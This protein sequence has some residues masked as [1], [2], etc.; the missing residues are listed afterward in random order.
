MKKRLLSYL[1][2]IFASLS[3]CNISYAATVSI[4][5]HLL[6]GKDAG[7]I[8]GNIV[9]TDSK[10]GLLL[11]PHL[12]NLPPGTHGFHIHELASCDMAGAAAGDH[13]DP[14]HTGKHLG[15]ANINGHLGDL[16]ALIVK[17]DGTADTPVIAPRLTVANIMEHSVIIHA[18]GDN[19]A[20]TP[21]KLGGGGARI[22]CGIVK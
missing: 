18:G 13:L 9:A 12:T 17:P 15:P 11:K 21:I 7:K 16:P 20:D 6:S 19:Y 2:I 1:S 4:P 5:I 14:A 10:E 3:F 8:I 22:A